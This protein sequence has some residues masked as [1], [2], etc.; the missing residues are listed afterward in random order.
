MWEYTLPAPEIYILNYIFFLVVL[1][2]LMEH[3]NDLFGT[4]ID[5]SGLEDSRKLLLGISSSD[6]G[7]LLRYN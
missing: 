6:L 2:C 5:A 3:K 1:N 4:N 7:F